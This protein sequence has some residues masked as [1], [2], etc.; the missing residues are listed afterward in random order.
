MSGCNLNNNRMISFHFQGKSFNTR[1]IQVYAPNSNAEEAE[2]EQLCEDLQELLELIP[3]KICPFHH[4]GLECKSRKSR[5]TW[6]NRPIW[7]WST[8]WSRAKANRV[9][10]RECT[11][12]SKHPFPTIQD[13]TVHMNITRW[14]IL[15]SDWLYSSQPKMERLCTVSRNKT[16]SWLWLRS[17]TPYCQIQTQ[18]EKAGK[19]TRPFRYDLSQIPY[20]YTVEVTNIFK[21][22]YLID[23][24]PEELWTEVH[25]IKQ[26]AV[27][28]TTPKKR[29]CKKV[30][31]LS[32]EALQIAEKRKVK[33]KGEKERYTYL[34]A[35][36]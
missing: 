18:I 17:W 30:K 31:W 3:P 10:P 35:E 12:H 2:V 5:D 20:D 19:T 1:I 14:L 23:R 9:W 36:F 22:L 24:V 7:S 28:K 11:G 27:I 8:K 26:E 33:S 25:D 21:Q 16:G 6:S 34:N 29:K 4:R 15:K 13:N 32:E